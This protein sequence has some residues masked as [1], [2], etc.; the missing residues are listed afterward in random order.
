MWLYTI[1]WPPLPCSNMPANQP[2]SSTSARKAAIILSPRIRSMPWLLKRPKPELPSPVWK[3]EILLSLA[4]AAR[5]Q[6]CSSRRAFHL[7]LYPASPLQLQH[8]P[9]PAFR[10]PTVSWPP[11][12]PL[13]PVMRIPKKKKPALTGK[14]WQPV[15]EHWFFLWA[16]KICPRLH[17]SCWITANHRTR[18]LRWFDGAR[19]P[20]R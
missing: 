3:A 13:S 1:I 15:S 19:P 4:A 8:R 12:W 16:S 18:R 20:A 14:H 17:A 7:R 9:M 5:K 10:W 2:S 11:P 6:K